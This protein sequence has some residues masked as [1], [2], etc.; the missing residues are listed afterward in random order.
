ME[1][2]FRTGQVLLVG[3]VDRTAEYE[4]LESRFHQGRP[5]VRFA[6]IETMS[7]AEGLAGADLWLREEDLEPLPAGTFYRHD[8]VGCD[9]VDTHGT[10]V[11]RVT[12]VEG[13]IDRSYLVVD[14]H[15][16]IPL[17]G[18]ICVGIDIGARRVTVDPPEGLLGEESAST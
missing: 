8:L 2:R 13:S 10:R 6:G 5:I 7:E 14:E 1:E 17:V 15:M 11:G 16:L 3:P 18:D 12:A 9:V 4:V